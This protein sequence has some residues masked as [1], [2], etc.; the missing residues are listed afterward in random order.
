MSSHNLAW[1]DLAQDPKKVGQCLLIFS[2]AFNCCPQKF[3]LEFSLKADVHFEKQ[4][5]SRLP[6]LKLHSHTTMSELFR[7]RDDFEAVLKQLDE[8]FHDDIAQLCA[9]RQFSWSP[10]SVALESSE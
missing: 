7:R 8:V 4:P 5:N 9:E 1:L 2:S 6:V 10:V 3:S